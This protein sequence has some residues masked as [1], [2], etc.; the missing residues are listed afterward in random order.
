MGN[1]KAKGEKVIY[2]AGEGREAAAMFAW[3]PGID[4][5]GTLPFPATHHNAQMLFAQLGAKFKEE[6]QNPSP[7][8]TV[9]YTELLRD[10]QQRSTRIPTQL[11]LVSVAASTRH[12]TYTQAVMSSIMRSDIKALASIRYPRPASAASS[13]P[14]DSEN[15]LL[16][17]SLLLAPE[18][19]FQVAEAAR[20]R[21]GY[22]HR[23]C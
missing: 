3:T 20:C 16:P 5:E 1:I 22:E 17:P 10:T 23:C 9:R 4:T 6:K 19:L 14:A 7:E 18:G 2:R 11:T 13:K 12:A 8:K 15:W 21:K